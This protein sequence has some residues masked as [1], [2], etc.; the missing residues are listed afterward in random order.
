M[1]FQALLKP[2]ID[3]TLLIENVA[4]RMTYLL[5]LIGVQVFFVISGFLITALLL[6][7]EQRDGR[8]SI[9]AFYARRVFRILPAYTIFLFAAYALRASGAL[10]ISAA[11]LA[12][13]GTFLCNTSIHE[14]SYGVAH[15]WSLAV[16]EQ[17][18]LAW[19]WLFVVLGPRWRVRGLIG[20]G[21]CFLAL[22]AAGHLHADWIDNGVFFTS[23]SVGALYACSEQVRR[24][25]LRYASPL[26]T[27]VAVGALFA[28]PY[29]ASVPAV[30]ALL[31][32]LSP[33]FIG[34]VFFGSLR[35]GSGLGKTLRWRP[36]QVMGWISYSVYLWQQL[37]TLRG[38]HV[39][40]LYLAA[41][42]ILLV[43]TVSFVLIE[44]PMV[45]YGH[46]LSAEIKQNRALA[47]QSSS[48]L[49]KRF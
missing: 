37:F 9:A 49:S 33:C 10:P 8:I 29:F 21:F 43:A 15:T 14:C 2:P 38:E 3:W 11:D 24:L 30:L 1:P 4:L 6:R 22:S 31:Q 25:V 20:I 36:L 47:L 34:F 18:Y 35:R 41:P 28:K 40:P 44:R 46:K 48:H 12:S 39:V 7:E 16:E 32:L 13:A 23:I 17:F 5:P 42:M 26:T 27:T 45:R 19:P